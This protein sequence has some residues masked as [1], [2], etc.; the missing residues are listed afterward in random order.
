MVWLSLAMDRP[1]FMTLSPSLSHGGSP[2]ASQPSGGAGASAGLFPVQPRKG[3]P[4]LWNRVFEE[5][6]MT[7]TGLRADAESCPADS[8]PAS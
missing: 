4:L 8:R 1:D 3:A 5:K 2:V 7:L 6:H